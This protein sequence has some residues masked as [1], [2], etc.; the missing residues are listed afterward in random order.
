[1]NAKSENKL[2]KVLVVD[3]NL[4]NRKLACAIL[5]S[6][7]LEFDIAENGKLAFD[8]FISG[9]YSLVLMDIQMPILNGI[10]STKLIRKHE[11]ENNIE[12][13]VPIIAVT[14]FSL[15]SDMTNCFEAGM[16]DLLAKPY[17][18]KD[19][20]KVMSKYIEIPTVPQL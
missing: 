6:C 4:L 14:T 15:H 10:E 12:V 5:K 16:N 18:T 1:M 7:D 20:V 19:L 11:S 17:K 8:T 13:L 3:D 9:D 2:N